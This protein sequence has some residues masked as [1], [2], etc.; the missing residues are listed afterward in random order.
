VTPKRRS[1]QKNDSDVLWQED[2]MATSRKFIADLSLWTGA[3]G[4]VIALG[5]SAE[6]NGP[7]STGFDFGTNAGMDAGE[8]P[9][10]TGA[11]GAIADTIPVQATGGAQSE[12]PVITY[13][14]DACGSV[15]VK[16]TRRTPLVMFVVDRSQTMDYAYGNADPDA[17]PVIIRW[18]A[19]HDAIMDPTAGVVAKTQSEIFIG[20][21][22]YDGGDLNEMFRQMYPP[23]DMECAW[24]PERAGC[25]DNPF[26]PRECPRLVKVPAA[27]NNYDAI[28]AV[29]TMEKAG[30]GGTTPTAAALEAAYKELA[31]QVKGNLDKKVNLN[32]VVILVTDGEPNGCEL[33]FKQNAEGQGG[34]P[35]LE[36]DYEGPVKQVTDAAKNGIKT[37][38]VG[39]DTSI[40]G[41]PVEV[42]PH[43]DTLAQ[44]G[45]DNKIKKAF[46]PANQQ[47]LA[48]TLTNLMIKANCEVELNQEIVEGKEGEG[49]VTLNSEKLE[50]NS[51]DGF[52]VAKSKFL[53][54]QGKAC[55]KL[56][57]SDN[58]DLS[59]VF[60]CEVIKLQ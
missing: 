56:S 50:F 33:K 23:S 59:A 13:K 18:A 32:P 2:N 55:E 46:L 8:A 19:L 58:V 35:E 39:I 48:S 54:L 7:S 12:T 51:P 4:I 24:E 43:L 60:P 3:I 1:G 38:V 41:S 45:S 53:T 25:P 9:P 34:M 44:I 42:G 29:Y 52:I 14:P 40:A 21:M 10:A 11:G 49:T 5:C 47:E 16:F 27:K 15:E 37:Y 31:D 28:A 6:K 36:G 17:G 20:I 57:K 30:P 26:P 22:L